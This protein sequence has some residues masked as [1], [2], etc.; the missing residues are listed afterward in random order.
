MKDFRTQLRCRISSKS[1]LCEPRFPMR[2][3]WRTDWR[4]EV[5]K[6][7]NSSFSLR[8]RLKSAAL[9]KFE[10]A[11]IKVKFDLYL[12]WTPHCYCSD[13]R[14]PHARW[15]ECSVTLPCGHYI[16]I[17]I[18]GMSYKT[19][20]HMWNIRTECCNAGVVILR[21]NSKGS[22]GLLSCRVWQAL[23]SMEVLYHP[24]YSHWR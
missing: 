22:R 4:P 1:V 6:L 5:T 2:I 15:W 20:I 16:K 14:K 24:C 11:S 7:K 8:P 17:L 12:T 3:D 23:H 19:D 21:D 10:S 9:S 13:I 18:I